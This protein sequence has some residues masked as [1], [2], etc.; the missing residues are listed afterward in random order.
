MKLT[1]ISKERKSITLDAT[2]NEK[3]VLEE[4]KELLKTENELTVI[5]DNLL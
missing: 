5:E 1:Q 2:L 3:R 4:K